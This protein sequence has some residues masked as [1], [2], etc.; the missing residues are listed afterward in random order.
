MPQAIRVRWKC[1]QYNLQFIL[2]CRHIYGEL[3]AVGN[4]IY[5]YNLLLLLTEGFSTFVLKNTNM[6]SRCSKHV[7][8]LETFLSILLILTKG[9]TKC[10]V[11]FN[12]RCAWFS[13]RNYLRTHLR[14]LQLVQYYNNQSKLRTVVYISTYVQIYR[15]IFCFFFFC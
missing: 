5:Y 14:N 12:E 3:N 6:F 2:N 1:L 8:L 9:K 13:M 11:F 7:V 4:L 15:N 10:Y